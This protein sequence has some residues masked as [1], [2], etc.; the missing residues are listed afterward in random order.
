M[1]QILIVVA[2]AVLLIWVVS[3]RRARRAEQLSGPTAA[4]ESLRQTRYG[5]VIGFRD[6]NELLCW[7][8]IPF[9]A[10]TTAAGTPCSC[11]RRMIS[12]S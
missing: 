7:Q 2:T 10:V 4:P 11:M 5:E 6:R 8:G 1:A 3:I 9:A 12:T